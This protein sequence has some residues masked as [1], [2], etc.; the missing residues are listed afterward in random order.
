MPP[1]V[2]MPAS[3]RKEKLLLIAVQYIQTTAIRIQC[4]EDFIVKRLTLPHYSA[5]LSLSRRRWLP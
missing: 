1:R 3:N 4:T 5:T 2:R